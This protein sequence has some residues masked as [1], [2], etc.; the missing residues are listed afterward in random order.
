MHRERLEP[1]RGR[2][3]SERAKKAS[4]N[5]ANVLITVLASGQVGL[6]E[7]QIKELSCKSSLHSEAVETGSFRLQAGR[8]VQTFE[9]HPTSDTPC[10]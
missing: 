1:E 7:G 10:M 6:L 4:A 5:L 2:R 8:E 9:H 3:E